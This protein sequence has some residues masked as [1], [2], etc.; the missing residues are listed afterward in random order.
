[1]AVKLT[2][3]DFDLLKGIESDIRYRVNIWDETMDS[4]S[5]NTIY[6]SEAEAWLREIELFRKDLETRRD[7]ANRECPKHY[8]GDGS[9]TCEDAMESML[10]A[11][12]DVKGIVARWWADA[13]K[14]VWRWPLKG[15]PSV[16][17]DKARS[18][19]NRLENYVDSNDWLRR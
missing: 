10:S 4:S 11:A 16:D 13:L 19:I 2:E 17:L 9:I 7:D 3:R 18:C 14:Y 6:A 5:T 1:M 12:P 8:L 15:Y